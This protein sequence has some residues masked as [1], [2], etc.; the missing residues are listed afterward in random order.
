[1]QLEERVVRDSQPSI[2]KKGRLSKSPIRLGIARLKM[3]R[4]FLRNVKMK[5]IVLNALTNQAIFT[6]A[7]TGLPDQLKN[8]PKSLNT[9]SK[10][11]NSDMKGLEVLLRL[12]KKMGVVGK[13]GRD[14]YKLTGLGYCLCKEGPYSLLGTVITTADLLTPAWGQL[15]HSLKTG[16]AAFEMA[17]NNELYS[18]LGKNDSDNIYFNMWME[19]TVREWVIPL[20]DLYDF[21]GVKT[22]V[23]VGGGTGDLVLY[24]LS[25]YPDARAILFDQEHVL[26]EGMKK[27]ETV[28][29]AGRCQVMPGDFF[30]EVPSEGDVYVIS[31]VLLN[32]D[33]DHA[34]KI[35]KNC[36]SVMSENDNLLI[37]DFVMPEK[38]AN[39]P[40]LAVSLNLL[41][42]GGQLM[43]TEKEY[44]SMLEKAGFESFKRMETG[45]PISVIEASRN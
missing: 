34:L 30:K 27:L 21:S 40:V 28:G 45:F 35:L 29:L 18:Y 25:K 44:F 1:M 41:V 2:N 4:H 16:K 10:E 20:L 38:M 9:L 26:R 17:F 11:L 23:D 13:V 36:R 33:D 24:L 32:W 15:P 8:G 22:L 43:R 39:L 14:R 3:L 6:A 7:R 12:L 19:E 31:R 5:K 37:I 42:L